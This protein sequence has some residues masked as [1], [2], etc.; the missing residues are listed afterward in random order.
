MRTCPEC[1]ELNGD[2]NAY[3]YKCNTLIGPVEYGKKRCPKCDISYTANKS[4]CDVCGGSLLTA[5]E[6]ANIDYSN[7]A[8]KSASNNNTWMYICTFFIPIL[9]VILGCIKLKED[10]TLAKTLIILGIVLM[11]I[12]AIISGICIGC[13]AHETAD[14]AREA[15]SYLDEVSRY[16]RDY[17]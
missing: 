15:S 1:G 14:A 9:G 12:Y 3:C 4:Y 7:Y 2:N 10:E 17:N 6:R 8:R 16:M 13:S 11:V 5:S